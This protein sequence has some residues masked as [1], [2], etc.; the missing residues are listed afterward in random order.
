MAGSASTTGESW[1]PIFDHLDRLTD[2][3]GLFEH[4]LVAEPRREYGYCV[5][6]AARALVVV[7]RES[8]PNPILRSLSDC[9]LELVLD[10]IE[11]DGTCHNRMSALG[12]W[13]DEAGVGDWW[14]RG[15]WGLGVCTA[16]APTAG[17]RSRA[18]NGFR[19]A[20]QRRSPHLRSMCYAAL[21]AAEVMRDRPGEVAAILLLRAMLDLI[22]APNDD[23]YWPWPEPRLTYANATVAQ[24]LIVAGDALDDSAA[25]G[26]GLQLLE[27]LMHKETSEGH[28]SVTPVGGRGRDD[29]SPGFDQQPI[30]VAA[31]A[32]ACAS[33][34]RITN[35]RQ[36][37]VGVELSWD[38]FLGEN[39]SATLMFDPDTG[40]AFDGL[41]PG[42]CNL[43]Q[44]AESTVAMLSTAQHA[45]TPR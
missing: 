13:Q 3:R 9:Y 37:R 41:E 44:G 22:G 26:Y 28:L 39:D 14:G 42:G 15:L 17:M 43:N 2:T 34:H 21:G 36:W 30:E 31:I 29:N 7:C 24:A 32:D 6:D 40:G 23:V 33:A 5:D 1:Q 25:L 18:L 12:E 16:T 8:Q 45:R 38:W 20:G 27:F 35:Q 4:A 19:L 11:A 10:A